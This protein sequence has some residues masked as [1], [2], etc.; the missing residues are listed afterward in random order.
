MHKVQSESDRFSAV[1]WPYCALG[2]IVVPSRQACQ[3]VVPQDSGIGQQVI[4]AEENQQK[5]K[6][7]YERKQSSPIVN[8]K[9]LSHAELRRAWILQVSN[10]STETE[11]G[12]SRVNYFMIIF[13]FNYVHFQQYSVWKSF[14]CNQLISFTI[15][16]LA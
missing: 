14:S 4:H 9:E 5:S 13:L 11:H 12:R 15:K 3:P 7:V 8:S 6:P 1:W 16:T 10:L 2:C